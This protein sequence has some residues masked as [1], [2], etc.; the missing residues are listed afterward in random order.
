[1]QRGRL[2]DTFI[3]SQVYLVFVSRREGDLE[4]VNNVHVESVVNHSKV[5]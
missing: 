2:Y 5:H 1:M 4:E 3:I